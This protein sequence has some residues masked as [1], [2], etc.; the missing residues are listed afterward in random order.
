MSFKQFTLVHIGS[1]VVP[2]PVF[3]GKCNVGLA[4][5]LAYVQ[6][7]ATNRYCQ[8]SLHD[9]SSVIIA[10]EGVFPVCNIVPFLVQIA[11]S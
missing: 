7:L 11:V 2:H 8:D 3:I 5:D 6:G 4:T 1:V 9:E 10:S